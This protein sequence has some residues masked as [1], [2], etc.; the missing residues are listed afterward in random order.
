VPSTLGGVVDVR[1]VRHGDAKVSLTIRDHGAGL[2]D[3]FTTT[4]SGGLGMKIV[5]ALLSQ[6][7][8][9]LAI[10]TYSPGT[11]FVVELPLTEASSD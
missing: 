3:G 6:C 10:E 5:R 9:T 2:P 7:R 11:G 1:L 4:A 8:A